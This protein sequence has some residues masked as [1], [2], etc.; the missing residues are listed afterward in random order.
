M[1]TRRLL[2][3]R[4]LLVLAVAGAAVVVAATQGKA[5][6]H[7]HQARSELSRYHPDRA[8]GHL[9]HCL[10][11]WPNSVPAHLLASRAAR[12]TGDFEVADRQLREAQR[13]SG[14]ST[15]E[16]ALEWAMFNAAGGNL[17]EVEEFLQRQAGEHPEQAPLIW[18]AVADG[19]VR[20]YRPLDAINCLELWLATDPHNVRALELRGQAYQSGKQTRKAADDFRRVLE[21]DPDR[22]ATRWRLVVCLLDAGGY[23]EALPLLERL[24]RE[25]PDDP[26]VQM[27]L[28]RCLYF[29]DRADQARQML[30]AVLERHPDHW[31]S[32]RTR[33]QFANSDGQP[34][35]AEAWLRRAARLAPDDY[36]TQFF[37]AQALQSQNKPEAAAQ[38]KLAEETKERAERLGE[39]QS[40]KLYERPNDPALNCEMGVA[41]MRGGRLKEAEGWLLKAV[42]LDP[43]YAPAH[44]ALVELYERQGD[45][46]RADEH[47]QQAKP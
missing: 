4:L 41:L 12:Q 9:E 42:N 6:Y 39:L 44:A 8:R 25:R 47:R 15:P 40:R 43:K 3:W 13:L 28:A 33:G 5:W 20:V 11:T 18:E 10:R 46:E 26:E 23:A 36:Q 29:V 32:L 19:Y 45:H 31:L 34:E 17:G 30:D 22:P 14:G 35:R 27:R 2:S 24:D 1:P 38:Q 16:T 7:L 21:L 37:L